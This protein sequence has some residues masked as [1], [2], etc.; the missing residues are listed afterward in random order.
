MLAFCIPGARTAQLLP[1]ALVYD[2]DSV[3]YHFIFMTIEDEDSASV[4]IGSPHE[5]V[6]EVMLL[7]V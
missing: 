1:A 7:I 4:S 3:I 5:T 2:S 6:S